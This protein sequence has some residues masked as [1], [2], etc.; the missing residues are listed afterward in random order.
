MKDNRSI[1]WTG[2]KGGE[3]YEDKVVPVRMR[4]Q[5][6]ERKWVT[7]S[8]REIKEGLKKGVWGKSI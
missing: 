5:T 4:T 8:L 1:A 2:G 3:G 7:D 6:I